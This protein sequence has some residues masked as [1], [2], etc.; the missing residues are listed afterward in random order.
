M[1]TRSSLIG[2]FWTA[3][4]AWT[5]IRNR[6]THAAL[7]GSFVSLDCPDGC[8]Y[9]K[10]LPPTSGLVE[11]QYCVDSFAEGSCDFIATFD[12]TLDE[13]FFTMKEDGT[14]FVYGGFIVDAAPLLTPSTFRERALSRKALAAKSR[15]SRESVHPKDFD[16]LMST[17]GPGTFDDDGLHSKLSIDPMW[18]MTVE[19]V[20]TDCPSVVFCHEMVMPPIGDC[21]LFTKPPSELPIPAKRLVET[22]YTNITDSTGN[23]VFK[24]TAMR[25]LEDR[26]NLTVIFYRKDGGPCET[27]LSNARVTFRTKQFLSASHIITSP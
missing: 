10:C 1:R 21:Q 7:Q 11:A 5:A 17:S 2:S 22:I 12:W 13:D 14:S 20:I 8:C 19:G 25:W 15:K 27:T 9:Q 18:P 23:Q 6:S 3:W 26:P 16:Q 24:T 4:T